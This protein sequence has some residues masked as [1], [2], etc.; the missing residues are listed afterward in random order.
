MNQENHLSTIL[1]IEIWTARE[2]RHKALVA[3]IADAFVTRRGLQLKH[4]VHDF[5]FTYYDLSPSKLKHWVPSFEEHLMVTPEVLEGH[6]WL[7]DF[8]F[9]VERDI[10]IPKTERIKENTRGLAR[11]V[12]ELCQSI[13]ERPYRLTC[14][15]LHE[16]AMVYKLSPE[17]IRHQGCRLR[18]APDELSSFVE[19]Q[20][21]CCSH[22][23][24]YRFFTPEALPLNRLN[25]ILETRLQ[26]EQGGCIHVNMDL[27]KW[28][29]KLWPW[30]GSDFITKTFLIA[31]EAREL[32]MRASPYDLIHEGYA[33]IRIETEEGRRQYQQEQQHLAERARPIREELLAFSLRLADFKETYSR[34]FK[35]PIVEKER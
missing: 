6:P 8:W 19:S 2:K 7:N 32:D 17:A 28:A 12:A 1:P 21:I 5:L 34:N 25:P 26:M 30:I 3:P 27:Y 31:L 15:G 14:F 11:F 18:L 4:P 23:D 16:W 24:A 22:Y 9:K 13:L 35:I 10:L 33:P 29:S 20:T